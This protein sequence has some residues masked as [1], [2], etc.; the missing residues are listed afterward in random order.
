[1]A[2][3]HMLKLRK[4][5]PGEPLIVSMT[6]LRL[7]ERVLFV[8][9]KHPKVIAQL[10]VRPGL[11]G[12]VCLV[13][14]NGERASQ[15]GAAALAEGGLVEV[16]TAP[17]TSLPYPTGTFDVVVVNH[18]LND[19]DEGR[20]LMALREATRVLRAGGRSIA[21]ERGR[22]PGLAGVFAA[23]PSL[24]ADQILTAMTSAELRGVR[25]LAERDGLMF[26]EGAKQN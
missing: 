21:I 6:G 20:Q 17:V 10:A 1:M 26:L 5:T 23:A 8:G 4:T 12:R 7:G 16:E 19:L 15:A 13:D 14:E 24:T 2:G 3:K 9:C 25:L 18:L 11:S 22:K